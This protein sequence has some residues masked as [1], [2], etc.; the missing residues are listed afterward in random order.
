MLERWLYTDRFRYHLAP[1]M[2]R[3]RSEDEDDV[4]EGIRDVS[5]EHFT[6]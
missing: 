1:T 3:A 6:E 5:N 2:K 4:D